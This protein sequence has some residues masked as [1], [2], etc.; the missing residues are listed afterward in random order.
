MTALGFALLLTGAALMVAEA[1]AP[2][3][4]F[5]VAGGLGLVVGGV[6]LIA[7][8]GGGAVLAVPVALGIGAVAAGWTVLVT[9]KAASVRGGRIGA[10]REALCGRIG[11][12]R[13]WHE[14]AGQVFVD[15]AL[16][17]AQHDWAG[18]EQGTLEE[19]DPVVVER[20]N[21]LTLMVRRA[22]D[23]ELVA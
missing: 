16:W 12:V 20:L 23:W 14:P 1:H 21:G 10:G 7:A 19:G 4:V 2:G 22:E 17:R 9:R 6:V 5:G 3:G 11:V 13:Q 8:L 15:G 18:R